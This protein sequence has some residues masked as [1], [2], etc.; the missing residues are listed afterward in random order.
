MDWTQSNHSQIT[1]SKNSTHFDPTP[2]TSLYTSL[3]PPIPCTC[4]HPPPPLNNPFKFTVPLSR[5]RIWNQVR[6]LRW[7]F[8][9]ENTQNIKPIGCFSRGAPSLMSDGILN[10]IPWYSVWGGF[11]HWSYTRGSWTT[12]PPP[13][14]CLLIL[15]IHTKD[16]DSR[17]KILDWPHVLIS[18]KENS[19]T[20]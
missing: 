10:V 1:R 15:L 19:S 2:S 5:I 13:P 4:T 17:M 7:S 11:H 8:F 9:G 16:K 20:G 3:L 18:F 14:P 12:P 6:S